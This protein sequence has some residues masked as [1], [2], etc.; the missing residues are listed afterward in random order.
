M[1]GFVAA[2]SFVAG[3]LTDVTCEPSECTDRWNDFA[4]R[5]GEPRVPRA[6]TSQ[7]PHGISCNLSGPKAASR[8]HAALTT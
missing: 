5:A 1:L 2:P 3:E 4:Q 8:I 6:T 7:S